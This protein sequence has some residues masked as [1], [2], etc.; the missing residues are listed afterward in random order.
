MGIEATGSPLSARQNPFAYKFILL[1]IAVCAL[2]FVIWIIINILK[3]RRLTPEYIEAQKHR[4]TKI[5]D[6][7][8]LARKLTLTKEESVLLWQICHNAKAENIFY[9]YIDAGFMYDIFK[10]EYQRLIAKSNPEED[11]FALFRLRYHIEKEITQTKRIPSTQALPADTLLIMP[12][13]NGKQIKFTV[14][15]VEKD[16]L[17]LTL[18]SELE[19]SENCPAPLSKIVLTFMHENSNQY[20]ISARVVRFQTGNDGS[21][22]MVVT[23]SNTISMQN[24]REY[25]RIDYKTDCIFSGIEES[26]GSKNEKIYTP[27]EKKYK[28]QICDISG[29]G[30]K[31]LT[32][33][34]IKVQQKIN[35][36]IPLSDGETVQSMGLIVGMHKEPGTELFALRISFFKIPL[37]IRNKILADIYKYR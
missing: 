36:E 8:A 6:V 5:E 32:D 1:A 7:N 9:N 23:H 4:T 33:L 22:Q 21:R 28:G 29:G 3:K 2:L 12:A 14:A 34:P 15:A 31:M 25:K 35:I 27:K 17:I 10:T 37:A 30:I 18:P 20:I 11:I 19:G 26:T 24:R 16:Y 13:A